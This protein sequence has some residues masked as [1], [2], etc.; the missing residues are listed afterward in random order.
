MADIEATHRGY[1]IRFNENSDE[2]YCS[3]LGSTSGYYSSPS[4]SKIKARID[5]MLLDVR[6]KSAFPCFEI[7]GWTHAR[8][9]KSEA[10]I[11]EYL[12]R[13]KSYNH[14]LNHGSGGY[15]PGPHRVA[16]VAQR[17]AN[18]KASRKEIEIN[19]LMPDTPEA[20]AAFVLF[21][22]ACR[23]EQAAKKATK[24]AFDAIPR[25][26]LDMI[27]DLVRIAEGGTE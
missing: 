22:E 25:V 13:G 2:W 8:A 24:A 7:G 3:E 11:T 9:E 26:T 23:R 16:S 14:K 18:E 19:T 4:L 27:P 17:G 20:H 12:G 5:K 10:Q 6:K 21:E 15:E 1:V